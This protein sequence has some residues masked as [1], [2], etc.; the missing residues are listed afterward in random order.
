MGRREHPHQDPARRGHRG[1][2]RRHLR[3]RPPLPHPLPPRPHRPHRPPSSR[4]VTGWITSPA[5]KLSS[6]EA[7]ALTALTARCPDLAALRGHVASFARALTRREGKDALDA[8]L[9]TAGSNPAQPELASFASGI[10]RDYQATA[11]ALTL[12]WS[13]GLVE[14]LNTRTKLLKRQMYGRATFPLLRKRILLAG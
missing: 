1:R 2:L 10:R 8:W 11:S 7:Q 9:A 4:Q 5:G 14:G 6:D 13:S 3:D 12:T